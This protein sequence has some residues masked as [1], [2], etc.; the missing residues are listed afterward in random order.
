M[1]AVLAAV[2]KWATYWRNSFI[3]FITVNCTVQTSLSTGNSMSNEIMELLRQLS[4][5]SVWY[6]FEYMSIYIKSSDNQLADALSR[7][8]EP[9]SAHRIRCIN[10]NNYL[11]CSNV[12][13]Y[14]FCRAWSASTAAKSVSEEC[15]CTN[16]MSYTISI[17]YTN[18][19]ILS[20]SSFG[21]KQPDLCAGTNELLISILNQYPLLLGF[22]YHFKLSVSLIC[23]I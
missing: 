23:V 10:I 6:N 3:I 7:L 4:W 17:W 22:N 5:I 19:L 11:C 13:Y 8:E 9:L 14:S 21:V 16:G 2:Q 20:P 15:L 12:F 18:I 1:G